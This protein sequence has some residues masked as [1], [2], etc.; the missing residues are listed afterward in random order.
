MKVN[1]TSK[2][3][4]KLLFTS[5]VTFFKFFAYIFSTRFHYLYL[6]FIVKYDE[7]QQHPD[8]AIIVTRKISLNINTCFT[9]FYTNILKIDYRHLHTN[10]LVS[11]IN[12]KKY[13]DI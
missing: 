4:M 1:V 11:L 5:E 3:L 13:L 12:A 10:L 8:N 7:K 9:L 6:K 2:I